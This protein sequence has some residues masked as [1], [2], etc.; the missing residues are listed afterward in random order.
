[1]KIFK[2]NIFEQTHFD[3]TSVN[4]PVKNNP[5]KS[6]NHDTITR[7]YRF[8]KLVVLSIDMGLILNHE[9]YEIKHLE[10]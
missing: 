5:T 9:K 4:I 10:F 8:K 3:V 1:M 2:S 7:K 6:Q